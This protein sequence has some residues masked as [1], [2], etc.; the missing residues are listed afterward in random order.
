MINLEKVINGC[1][2]RVV[3]SGNRTIVGGQTSQAT[4]S[5]FVRRL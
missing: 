2:Q 4:R 3:G 1:D 5:E